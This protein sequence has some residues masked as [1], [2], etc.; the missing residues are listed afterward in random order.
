LNRE[1]AAFLIGGLAFGA[2]LGIGIYHTIATR[3]DAGTAQ[4]AAAQQAPAPAGPAPMVG[5]GSSAPMLGRIEELKRRVDADPKDLEAIME[6]VRLY[7]S[8]GML[9]QAGQ[10]FERA[11]A[12]RPDDP[13]LVTGLAHLYHDASRWEQAIRAYER[14]LTLRPGDPD[15]TTDMGICYRSIGQPEKAIE[16]FREAHSAN[17]SHW[18]SLYNQVVVS[19]FD[20]G[21]LDDAEAG[22]AELERSHPD[23]QNLDV[24]RRQVADL[25]SKAGGAS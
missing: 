8:A 17:P 21:K 6:L 22:L 5:D 24:L 19:A 16:L 15:L 4:P 18:Q 20:L 9:D 3:P 11:V 7:H 23:A 25:R 2:L 1:N 12:E 10:W 14:A 13:A